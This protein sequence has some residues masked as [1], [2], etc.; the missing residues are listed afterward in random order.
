MFKLF[1]NNEFTIRLKKINFEVPPLEKL[2][3]M[4]QIIKTAQ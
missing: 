4:E 2:I 3:G 1:V